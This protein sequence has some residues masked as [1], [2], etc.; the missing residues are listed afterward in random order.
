MLS[1]LC[2]AAS[3]AASTSARE[4]WSSADSVSIAL[5]VCQKHGVVLF[6]LGT[7]KAASFAAGLLSVA[8]A[9]ARW[10]AVH[11][12]VIRTRKAMKQRLGGRRRGFCQ[13]GTLATEIWRPLYSSSRER[14]PSVRSAEHEC[15]YY[16]LPLEPVVSW[17]LSPTASGGGCSW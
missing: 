7:Q 13:S 3:R 4:L 5:G 11:A 6:A 15:R 14:S 1:A 12:S 16:P 9:A 17:C 8:A 2:F 10:R